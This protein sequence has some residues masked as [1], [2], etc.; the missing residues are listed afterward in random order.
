MPYPWFSAGGFR[1]RREEMPIYGTDTGWLRTPSYNRQRPLGTSVDVVN[2]IAIGSAERSFEVNLTP[3]RYAVL[4][5][6][7]NTQFLFT[8]WRRPI[9][10]SRN[11]FLSEVAGTIQDQIGHRPDGIPQRKIRTRISLISA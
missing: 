10:D 2:A 7:L 5:S 11:A 1:F 3:A 4:E 9:P 6:L 8:D